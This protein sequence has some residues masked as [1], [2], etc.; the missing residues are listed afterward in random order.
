MRIGIR[1]FCR[2]LTRWSVSTSRRCE[3]R[4]TCVGSS[5]V[6]SRNC[7]GFV[8]SVMKRFLLG[9]VKAMAMCG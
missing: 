2:M 7:R 4:R 1:R 3:S 9:A 6:C 5:K 8:G